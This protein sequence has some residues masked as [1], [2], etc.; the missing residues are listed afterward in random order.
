MDALGPAQTES[1]SS[2]ETDAGPSSK[3]INVSDFEAIPVAALA[4][5]LDARV[6]VAD[7][8][9]G[10][11][12]GSR[13]HLGNEYRKAIPDFFSHIVLRGR[14]E[15]INDP[16]TTLNEIRCKYSV[17][18]PL[19]VQKAFGLVVIRESLLV[20]GILRTPE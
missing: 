6:T 17:K 2:L 11:L 12:L 15:R 18:L 3:R 16:I 9:A 8:E 7:F 1:V 5:K 20:S 10:Y 14:V 13:K 19:F 4:A